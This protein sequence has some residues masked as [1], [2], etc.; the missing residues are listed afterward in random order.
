MMKSCPGN[1]SGLIQVLTR[2]QPAWL[3]LWLISCRQFSH[4]RLRVFG[5]ND[6]I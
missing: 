1:G 3:L 6:N 5:L 4:A 2:C